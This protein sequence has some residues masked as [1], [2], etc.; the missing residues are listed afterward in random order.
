MSSSATD[1]P[2]PGNDTTTRISN[3]ADRIASH[4]H[5]CSLKVKAAVLNSTRITADMQ[6]VIN[7]DRA[8][9]PL[10]E[11][12]REGDGLNKVAVGWCLGIHG[13]AQI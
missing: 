12:R 10:R 7:H 6:P 2:R 1:G 13:D 8:R 5:P 4:A 3:G 11:D 9:A